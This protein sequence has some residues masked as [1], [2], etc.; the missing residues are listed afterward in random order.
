[1]LGGTSSGDRLTAVD[2]IHLLLV[3]HRGDQ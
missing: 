2:Q 1:M 3:L